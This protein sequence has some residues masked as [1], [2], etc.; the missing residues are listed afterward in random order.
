MALAEPRGRFA[1]RHLVLKGDIVFSVYDTSRG[2]LLESLH[3]DRGG[4]F[5]LPHRSYT[6]RLGEAS[7]RR[8][9]S[10]KLLLGSPV[11]N[12]PRGAANALASFY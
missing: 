8:E 7:R 10:W 6:W 5:V 12:E 2:V 11:N 3:K 1:C 4:P 9:L